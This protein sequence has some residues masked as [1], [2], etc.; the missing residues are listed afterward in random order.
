MVL[1]ILPSL[2]TIPNRKCY[3]DYLFELVLLLPL[4]HQQGVELLLGVL[5]VLIL[6][7]TRSATH[8]MCLL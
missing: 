5:Q 2:V 3:Y 7:Q 8:I 4:S 1:Y 6:L